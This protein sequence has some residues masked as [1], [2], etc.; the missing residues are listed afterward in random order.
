[1]KGYDFTEEKLRSDI[2][3][4][5]IDEMDNEQEYINSFIDRLVEAVENEGYEWD[6]IT[7]EISGNDREEALETINECFLDILERGN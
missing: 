6:I 1:M 5:I 7:G 2:L 4:T 3:N